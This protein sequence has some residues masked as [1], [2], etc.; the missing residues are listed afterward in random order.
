MTTIVHTPITEEIMLVAA[1]HADVDLNESAA[2]IVATL[3]RNLQTYPYGWSN[4]EV[5][6]E[7]GQALTEAGIAAS[8][9]QTW[10]MA[11]AVGAWLNDE[12]LTEDFLVC[13]YGEHY[14]DPGKAY[15]HT[16]C[17]R[18]LQPWGDAHEHTL[19]TCFGATA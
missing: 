8:I 18:L 5:V 14:D 12:I 4:E 16:R 7:V 13:C 6:F 15:V 2:R 10:T 19:C 17:N 9:D 1:A 3:D 11:P